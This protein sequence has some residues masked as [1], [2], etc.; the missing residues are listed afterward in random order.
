[1][2][3]D[4]LVRNAT[5]P[6]GR[7]RLDIAARDGRIVAIAPRL[8]AD[9][10]ETLDANGRL[11]T[12][13]VRRLPFPS[14]RD[15][16]AR[17]A[18]AQHVRHAARRHRAV[19]RAEAAADPRGGGRARAALLR[20]RR[21]A[22]PARD[23]HPCRRLRRPAAGGRGAARRA[24]SRSRPTSTCNSSPSRRTA[25]SAR[26]PRR[27]NLERA[28]DLGVDVVGGIPH[29]ERT[30]ADGAASVTRAV[31]DRRGAR[32]ADRPALRRERRSAVAPHRDPGGARRSGS[33]S[34]PARRRATRPRCIRWTI[35]TSRS[36]SR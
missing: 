9:A 31:R 22:R 27:A 25:I 17:P 11:V 13:A 8:A 4:L 5:L 7:A 26:P 12:P 3:F 2:T 6:D 28:L 35:T 1:M 29:F 23:P 20:S 24:R 14:R 36:S 30:M 34:A 19:G 21:V 18:A 15:A 10:R 33:G 32:A 16:V